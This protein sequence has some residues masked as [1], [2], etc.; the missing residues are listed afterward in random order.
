MA[1][2][3]SIAYYKKYV[4]DM[5]LERAE[6]FQAVRQW[7]D[8]AAVLYPGCFI[9]VTPSFSFQHVVY[10]DYNDLARQFFADAPGVTRFVTGRKQYRQPPYIRFIAQDYTTPL[11][12]RAGSFDLLLALYAGGI[13]QACWDYL[14]PGGLLLSNN[15]HD[16]AGWAARS[17]AYELAAVIHHKGSACRI[18]ETGL[19][20]YFVPKT[21]ARRRAGSGQTPYP[22]YTRRADY[23]L[24]RKTRPRP[25]Q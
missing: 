2:P 4:A 7:A 17:E 16:D 13:P 8:V 12:L 6:V 19:D 22:E 20:G 1:A 15:H 5:G 24:F 9:H 14:R 10:V 18:E 21:A 3:Q 25:E 23:Y 11:P